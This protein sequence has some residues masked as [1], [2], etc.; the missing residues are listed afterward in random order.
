MKKLFLHGFMGAGSDWNITQGLTP[1]LPC[2]GDNSEQFES[3]EELFEKLYQHFVNDL[4][5][6][7]EDC[8]IGYSLGGRVVMELVYKMKMPVNRCFILCAHPG[9]ASLEQREQ[10]SVQEKKWI[11][12]LAEKNKFLENWYKNDLFSELVKLNH[13]NELYQRRLEDKGEYWRKSFDYYALSKQ[14]DLSPLIQNSSIKMDYFYGEF[15]KKFRAIAKNLNLLG[16]HITIHQVEG[17]DHALPWM[18]DI[19]GLIDQILD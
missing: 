14:P 10:R 13:F 1:D 4:K 12:A 19:E 6:T 11:Q 16:D 5:I 8:I 15:D 2:F 18:C 17:A 3:R 9:L 7:K